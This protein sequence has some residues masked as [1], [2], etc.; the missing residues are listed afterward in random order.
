MVAVPPLPYDLQLHVRQSFMSPR[1]KEL[2]IITGPELAE[3]LARRCRTWS[4]S[5]VNFKNVTARRITI[6][7]LEPGVQLLLADRLPKTSTKRVKGRNP[8]TELSSLLGTKRTRTSRGATGSGDAGADVDPDGDAPDVDA[9]GEGGAGDA[10]EAVDEVVPD[11]VGDWP[12]GDDDGDDDGDLDGADGVSTTIGISSDSSDSNS[13]AETVAS[14]DVVPEIP[15]FVL[16][17]LIGKGKYVFTS[18]CPDTHSLG[19]VNFLANGW[20]CFFCRRHKSPKCSL[21]VRPEVEGGPTDEE[22]AA[23][24]AR[25]V[26]VGTT[27]EHFALAPLNFF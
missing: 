25:G 24:I 5:M 7:S 13:D 1:L 3:Y 10:G 14:Y 20:K 27:A 16:G 22:G 17:R 18:D 23:W 4:L 2:A 8:L 6:T 9:A 21:L 12:D 15:D 19:R 26:G 11:P